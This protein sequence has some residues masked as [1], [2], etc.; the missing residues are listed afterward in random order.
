MTHITHT[1]MDSANRLLQVIAHHGR[2]FFYSDVKA[3]YASF[4][5]DDKGQLWFTDD[6]SGKRLNITKRGLTQPGFTHGGT[7]RGLVETLADYVMTGQPMSKEWIAPACTFGSQASD[8]WG[9][10]AAAAAAVRAE[11]H[12]LPMFEA[13]PV[14]QS[15]A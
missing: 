10:G 12:R 14:V 8:M 5:L 13:D 11:A 6:Y 3:R 15:A 1:R 7:L 2:R 9:Y 4:D